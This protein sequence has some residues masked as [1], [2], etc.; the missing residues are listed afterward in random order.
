[1]VLSRETFLVLTKTVYFH[2]AEFDEASN[3][4]RSLHAYEISIWWISGAR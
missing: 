3:I 2:T 1:L 4:R